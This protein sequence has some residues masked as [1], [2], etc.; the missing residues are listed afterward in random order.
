MTNMKSTMGFPTS[1]RWSLY[2]TPQFRKGWLNRR[3]STVFSVS[4]SAI[5]RSLVDV[6]RQSINQRTVTLHCQQRHYS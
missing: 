3:F 4:C 1:C 5:L 6:T 2:F